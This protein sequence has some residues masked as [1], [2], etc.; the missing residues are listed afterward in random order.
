MSASTSTQIASPSTHGDGLTT[1]LR[2]SPKKE[3]APPLEVKENDF[4]WTYTEEP[5]R[6]R[7]QAI[8]KAHPEVN[9]PVVTR[10]VIKITFT[11]IL[12]SGNETLWPRTSYQIR[13][14][15]RRLDSIALRI[16]P[17]EYALSI[18]AVLPHRICH[19]RHREPESVPGYP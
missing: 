9:F 16:S 13:R 12:S 17:T 18:M 8:I 3:A 19:W 1:R 5:H 6:T 15:P 10:S 14:C 4:F 11:D 7:R 2:T